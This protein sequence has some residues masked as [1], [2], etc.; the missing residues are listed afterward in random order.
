MANIRHSSTGV[1]TVSPK[2]FSLFLCLMQQGAKVELMDFHGNTLLHA[3]VQGGSCPV[4]KYTLQKLRGCRRWNV[5]AVNCYME[6]AMELA[7]LRGG[8]FAESL[9]L[10]SLVLCF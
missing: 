3:A 2:L 7:A 1:N 8:H 4:V 6:T 9:L 5:N 10:S